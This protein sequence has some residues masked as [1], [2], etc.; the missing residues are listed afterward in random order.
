MDYQTFFPAVMNGQQPYPYQQR[1]GEEEWPHLINVPTGMGKTASVTISWLFKRGWRQGGRVEIADEATPRRLIWCLPMRVLVE[2]A[3]ESIRGWLRGLDVLGDVGE[4][5]VSVHI[6]QGG[7]DDLKTWAEYPEEDMILIGTQDMLLSRALMRGY[8][9]NRYQWP[10]HFSLLHNDALWVFDEVQLMGAGLATSAQLEAFRRDFPRAKSSRSLWL[11]ATLNPRWLNTVD[12]RPHLPA[13]RTLTID[14]SD[15][16]KAG[17]RLASVKHLGPASLSLT[18]DAGNK[19]G[20]AAYLQALADLVL[21]SHTADSQT[22]V[23]VNRV[24]RAQGLFRLLQ[25]QRP[26]ANDLLIHSRFRAAE[27]REQ[28]RRLREETSAD[29]IIIATQAIEAGVDISSKCLIT[30]LAPWSSLVQRFGRC[31]RYGEHNVQGGAT[32]LWVNIEDDADCLPYQIEE[33]CLARDK[34][35]AL[36]SASPDDL[37]STD[38]D[39]P[40]STVIRRKDL[41]ELFN[42]DPDLS[43]FDVDVSD[44]IRDSGLPGIQVFWRDFDKSPNDPEQAPALRDE[45]CPV[46]ISQAKGL[47]KRSMGAWRWDSLARNWERLQRDP[48]PGMTLLLHANDGGYDPLVGFDAGIKKPPVTPVPHRQASSAEG[49][50]EDTRSQRPVPVLLADHL[51]H[52][53]SQVEILCQALDEQ[54]FRTPLVRAG[55]WHDVGK[56]HEVFDNTMHACEQ[57]PEGLLAKS[58]CNS[59]HQRPYFRHELASMLAWLA[60]HGN[61]DQADLIAYLIAAHHGK[62]RMSL[63]AMPDEQAPAEVKRF[64][65]GIWE[66]DELPALEFDGEQSANTRLSLALMELGEG[67]QGPSWTARTLRLLD[68]HG[69]FRLAWLETLVRLADWRASAAEQQ[70]GGDKHE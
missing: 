14:E 11:S 62:V 46:A 55:R 27:R 3:E 18:K 34:I 59:R 13:L 2:Q 38:E 17:A 29:R 69:P 66:G 16:R 23:I 54:G 45:L 7:A 36:Q 8:G 57:A 24:D 68:E 53:A 63:R 35:Q 15:R 6:L 48:R 25:R 1:L 51:S 40:L 37:P 56:A 31:N 64:A 10:V 30:E 43:G 52:V 9:M 5:K 67:E 50:G 32:I 4:G 47:Q 26:D 49:F 65:R 41:L 22:L 60:Q 33:L 21:Q 20:K 58:P 70:Q 42:T 44:Y 19:Q 28:S 61:E 39:R 12:L